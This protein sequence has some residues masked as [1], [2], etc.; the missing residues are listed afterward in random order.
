MNP[1][2]LENFECA[3]GTGSGGCRRVCE[4]GR[5]FYNPEGGW[6]WDDGELEDLEKRGATALEYTV[7]EISFEGKVFVN[8][9]NCWHPRAE[10]LID[11]IDGHRNQIAEFLTLEKKRKQREANDAPV[12]SWRGDPPCAKNGRCMLDDGH[13]GECDL[14]PF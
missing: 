5:E 4:C 9:C 3:F 11:W 13:D 14:I 1:L 8:G 2:L 12:V 6:D 10:R 7:G